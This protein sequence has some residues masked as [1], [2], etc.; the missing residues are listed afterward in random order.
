M[1]RRRVDHNQKE[2]TSALRRIGASVAILS[3][4]G[5]GVPDLL[6]GYHGKNYL[7]ELKDG[8]KVAS[9]KK[10]TDDEKDFHAI[11]KG[12]IDIAESWQDAFKVIGAMKS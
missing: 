3:M 10:L 4:V 2:V 1:R 6:V 8:E 11:W 12:R 5:K 7:I 9:K